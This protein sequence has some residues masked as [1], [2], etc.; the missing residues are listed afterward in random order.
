MFVTSGLAHKCW[1]YWGPYSISKAALEAMVK[2]YAGETA[3]T[4][5]RVNCFSP[6]PTR[7]KHARNAMPGEDPETLPSRRRSGRADGGHVYAGLHRH[8]HGVEICVH[9]SLQAV[10]MSDDAIITAFAEARRSR[11]P[12]GGTAGTR[13]ARDGPRL[14]SAAGGHR[15][16]GLGAMRLE[17]R[18]HQP[19][20]PE[21][22]ECGRPFS[23]HHVRPPRVQV[24][25]PCADDRRAT[26]AWWNPRWPSRWR[27]RC[28]RAVRPMRG[29]TC[30]RQWRPCMPR[31]KW[32]IRAR[33]RASPIRCRGSWSMAG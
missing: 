15:R 4:A 29:T 24:R 2:T 33:R 26:S 6:G 32:S 18:L 17:D 23:R 14:P 8:G 19:A 30:C 25:R 20:R 1:A 31:S 22:A 16:A 27:S 7:T 10:R 13:A 3:T 5:V 28:R 11:S 9:R 21:G 12:S